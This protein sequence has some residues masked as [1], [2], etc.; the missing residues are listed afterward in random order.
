MCLMNASIPK[1]IE[2]IK[3]RINNLAY[4]QGKIYV[5]SESQTIR[6]YNT[7]PLEYAYDIL[8]ENKGE[9]RWG[10]L[11]S[12]PI[13]ISLNY[14]DHQTEVRIFDLVKNEITH[15]FM[16]DEMMTAITPIDQHTYLCVNVHLNIFR[17]DQ[18][19]GT[20]TLIN[21]PSKSRKRLFDF[22]STLYE[23]LGM[24]NTEETDRNFVTWIDPIPNTQRYIFRTQY[25]SYVF[26]LYQKDFVDIKNYRTLYAP[27]MIAT[28]KYMFSLENTYDIHSR[29]KLLSTRITRLE[30]KTDTH[31]IF[32]RVAA[33]RIFVC[34]QHLLIPFP[35]DHYWEKFELAI[36]DI[37]TLELIDSFQSDE[38]YEIEST[39][40]L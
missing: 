39:T 38:L 30:F 11:G 1:K 28:E 32:K 16:I 10:F 12:Q 35:K 9:Y 29:F 14:S 13:V 33:E 4:Y 21:N 3:M 8:F 40:Y 36:Y 15:E 37:D 23:Y 5:L 24:E 34:G 25:C 31:I 22:S 20:L 6:V 27:M 18:K 7:K 26:D 19:D 2:R 17:F